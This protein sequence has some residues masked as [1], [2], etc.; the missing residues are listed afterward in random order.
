MVEEQETD[1]LRRCQL[2]QF[3]FDHTGPFEP[4]ILSSEGDIPLIQVFLLFHS[5]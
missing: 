4:L 2:G 5:F 3:Q 1:V